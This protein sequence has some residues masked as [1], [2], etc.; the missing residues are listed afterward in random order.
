[1]GFS[2]DPANPLSYFASGHP[3]SGGNLGV[4]HSTDGGSNWKQISEGSN[5]PVDF[6]Q[7]DVSL[8]DP[9]TLYG[10][11]GS[12]QVSHDGGLTWSVAGTPPD[13]LIAIA[14][15]SISAGRV[16]A[17]TKTG[18]QSSDDSGGTWRQLPLTTEPVSMVKSGP[19][20]ALFAFVVGGGFYGASEREP[21]VWTLLSGDF[22]RR[23]LLHLAVDPN[24]PKS[25]FAT[26]VENEVLES[27]DGGK[28]WHVFG[29]N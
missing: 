28:T 16:Y 4:I 3:A 11:Y 1:M 14:A 2:P 6:H 12:L 23:I 5:G 20:G 27:A 25:L 7:M 17:A 10:V 29:T 24:N 21:A 22:G 19:N 15:S 18:L 9:K 8:A 13:G 26:T